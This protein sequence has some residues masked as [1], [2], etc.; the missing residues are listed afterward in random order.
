M[1]KINYLNNKDILKEIHKSKISFCSYAKSE[2]SEYDII[3]RDLSDIPKLLKG[4]EAAARIARADRLTKLAQDAASVDG[5]KVKADTVA[6]D[7]LT[8][9]NSDI[10]FR[11]MTWNHIP[12]APP[13]LPK[14]PKNKKSKSLVIDNVFDVT[15]TEYD[16][17]V[18]DIPSPTKYVKVNFQ[19]FQHFKLND[20]GNLVC[21]G[22]SHWQGDVESGHFSKDHG[23]ITNTLALM[24]MKLCE[25]Y[26]TRSNWRGYTYVDEMKSTAL[27]QLSQI[28]LQFDESVSSNPFAYYTMALQNSF[29]RVLNIEKRN[30]NIRD[31]ILEMNN[32]A[33]SFSRQNSGHHASDGAHYEE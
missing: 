15:N 33:P 5:K 24:Y 4:E 14:A 1:R 3:I 11:L 13:A 12:E 27:L 20:N 23:K 19:P 28:G 6:V 22:K 32:L 2:Y 10:I 26:A 9:R 25:R 8:V 29:T 17:P 18:I 21:I 31:D 16:I 7:P 30:Q